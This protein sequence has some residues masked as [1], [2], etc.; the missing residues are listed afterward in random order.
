MP[1]ATAPML[2]TPAAA[3]ARPEPGRMAWLDLAKGWAILMVVAGHNGLLA[4]HHP[5][6]VRLL[7]SVH[8]P[9]FFALAGA[10]L[11]RH[12]TGGD[13][14][15]RSLSLLWVYGVAALLFLPKDLLQPG[16]LDKAVDVLLGVLY[17]TGLTIRAVPTWFLPCLAIT[18]PLAWLVM[19]INNT[20]PERLRTTTLPLWAALLLAAGGQLASHTIH[21]DASLGM[22][23]L[24]PRLA[25][26][27][28]STAGWM[29]S[30]D[31]VP[32]GMGYSLLGAAAAAWL[33]R[34]G[35]RP[36]IAMTAGAAVLYGSTLH[37]G[38]PHVDLNLRL[39]GP[40]LALALLCSATG[41]LAVM[42][43]AR[44]CGRTG[45]AS[46]VVAI[47]RASLP[48]LVFH[49]PI[50]HALASRLGA[51]MPA[52]PTAVMGLSMLAGV[53]IPLALDA[54]LLRRAGWAACLFYPRAWLRRHHHR[55][56]PPAAG[57]AGA[58][59]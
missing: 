53:A 23:P 49:N 7:F 26:G 50:Q 37:A 58:A 16:G 41:V 19:K 32:L 43:L 40:P 42:G 14:M 38:V 51:L 25:W 46:G 47:G 36:A 31:L 11:N 10:T 2:R 28:A 45:L 44:L 35:R 33:Q 17:G 8:V 39:L 9:L 12:T 22:A 48:I 56:T 27:Q 20:I 6:A 18:L 4:L 29:W 21:H 55:A 34:S 13:A 1:T 3:T 57:A 30:A 54:V 15:R 59:P 24:A 5:Q 52:A